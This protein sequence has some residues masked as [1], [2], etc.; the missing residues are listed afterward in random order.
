MSATTTLYR[1]TAVPEIVEPAAAIRWV[2]CLLYDGCHRRLLAVDFAVDDYSAACA[3]ARHAADCDPRVTGYAVLRRVV[4]IGRP[5][6]GATNP[7]QGNL[8]RGAL[9]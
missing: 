1:A 4:P 6:R 7:R 5:D 2:P 8:Q 3:A 9:R